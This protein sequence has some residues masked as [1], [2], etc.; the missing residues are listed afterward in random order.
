M[1]GILNYSRRR[2]MGV[3]VLTERTVAG[4]SNQALV[5]DVSKMNADI[6]CEGSEAENSE[7]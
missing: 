1:E 3:S 5:N 4:K 6:S 7:Y 2:I